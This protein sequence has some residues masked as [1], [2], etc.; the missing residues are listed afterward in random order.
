MISHS[1]LRFRSSNTDVDAQLSA[2]HMEEQRKARNTLMK[3]VTTLQYL[4]QQGLPIRGKEASDGN[5]AK[6]LEL[7]SG[8]DDV[9]KR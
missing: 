9:L 4:A 2:H 3:I 6:L 1:N 5:F 8:D 7:R